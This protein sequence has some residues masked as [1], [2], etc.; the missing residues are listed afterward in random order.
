MDHQRLKY[1]FEG[2]SSGTLR[3]NEQT[4]L[5]AFLNNPESREQFL[6]FAE[7]FTSGRTN[8]ARFQEED[9][10]PLIQTALQ[11][12]TMSAVGESKRK[13]ARATWKS[14]VLTPW[15]R[16]AAIVIGV[17]G[18]SIYFLTKPLSITTPAVLQ[19]IPEGIPHDV[20]PGGDRAVLKLADGSLIE[21]DSADAGTLAT[22]GGAIIRK[23]DNGEIL[24]N[25][26]SGSSQSPVYNTMS[27]PFGG[28]YRLVLPD[29]SKVWLNAASSITYPTVFTGEE[30]RVAVSGEVYFEVA[31]RSGVEGQRIP[32]L[33]DVAT[34]S[35]KKGTVKVLGTRFNVDAYGDDG[36]IRTTL[37]E[38]KVEI[39][40][41]GASR[42]LKP[43][44]QASWKADSFT[45]RQDVDLEAVV[46]WK[47]GYFRFNNEEIG[48]IMKQI[49]RWYNV[50]IAYEGKMRHLN[51]GGVVSRKENVSAVLDLLE[52]TGVIKF[53]IIPD[54]KGGAGKI[55]VR[56]QE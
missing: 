17:V 28:Q 41:A 6:S 47:N 53:Q 20:S 15:F 44:Q 45:L 29:G 25:A 10:L 50:E 39:N 36:S 22:E 48:V 19:T 43:G 4:E 5:K 35:G 52:L 27:T 13:R 40:Y 7:E 33:V 32:F 3:E 38:G 42:L 12:D 14:R 23:S 37:L 1:L 18:L 9:W 11:A 26:G 34:A 16:Y 54:D 30:R 24:Y 31:A 21:L 56:M 2:L 49:Q 8:L 55:L 51:F 46:A